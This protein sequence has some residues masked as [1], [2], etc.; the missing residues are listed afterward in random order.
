MGER[1]SRA[2]LW[3]PPLAYA[4]VTGWI[5]PIGYRTRLRR[6]FGRRRPSFW[7]P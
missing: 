3:I 2:V 4:G 1:V 5:S 6:G 7:E